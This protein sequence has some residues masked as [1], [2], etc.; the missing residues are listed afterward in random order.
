M[1]K[2]MNVII[3][4]G[5]HPLRWGV[6]LQVLLEK[7]AGMCL[8]DKLRSIQLYEA[9][10]NWYMKFIFSDRA[11][12]ALNETRMLPEEHFS[13]KESMAEDACLNKTITMDISRQSRRPMAILL[14]DA[15]Q[16]YD[17]VH[18]IMMSL[19]WLV[20]LNHIPVI[21]ILLS[22]LQQMKIFTR[23]GFG[24]SKTYFGGNP[25]TPFAG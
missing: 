9:D 20:L 24:D 1:A 13:Q 21:S 12:A 2:Q 19:V 5:V 4:S 3:Q 10:V 25:T 15:A 17:R 22:C 7:V 23:T 6:A 11:M 14:L 16:C 18:P 8:V